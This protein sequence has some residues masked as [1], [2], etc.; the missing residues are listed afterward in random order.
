MNIL[1]LTYRTIVRT[2]IDYGSIVY[3]S[4]SHQILKKLDPILHHAIRIAVGAFRT[5]PIIDIL[6]EAMEVP[7]KVRRMHL[8]IKF[9][10][11][12]SSTRQNPVFLNTF[13]QNAATTT[14]P[15]KKTALP[16]YNRIFPI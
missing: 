10:A 16:F 15:M 7:L 3:N 12:I 8:S 14:H 6:S 9:A 11:K 4:A 2:K 13:Q 1:L 5:D